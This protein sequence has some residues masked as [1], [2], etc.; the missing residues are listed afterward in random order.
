MTAVVSRTI[1]SFQSHPDFP[2]G[3]SLVSDE[4]GKRLAAYAFHPMQNGSEQIERIVD[5]VSEE[6]KPFNLVSAPALGRKLTGAG[7]HRIAPVADC[8]DI[9]TA[10]ERSPT[11]AGNAAWVSPVAA[12]NAKRDWRRQ[13]QQTVMRTRR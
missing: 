2:A 7:A 9:V 11:P 6:E 3:T 1:A 12:S 5:V 13:A 10:D 4:T 8:C